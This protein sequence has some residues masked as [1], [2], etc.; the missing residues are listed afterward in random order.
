M[1][2][3]EDIPTVLVFQVFNSSPVP[4]F[5]KVFELNHRNYVIVEIY[6]DQ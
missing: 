2:I 6:G 4:E 3:L 5:N 1:K